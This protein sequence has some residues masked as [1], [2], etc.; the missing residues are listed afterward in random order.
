[1]SRLAR[2]APIS[3]FR[4]NEA[5]DAML[6]MNPKI[7]ARAN[8]S[9]KVLRASSSNTTPPARISA[10]PEYRARNASEAAV[11]ARISGAHDTPAIDRL[12]NN[13]KHSEKNKKALSLQAMTWI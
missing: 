3:L 8:L 2:L 10:A 12:S 6:E 13:T 7:A 4:A 11:A 5:I 9:A 1:M